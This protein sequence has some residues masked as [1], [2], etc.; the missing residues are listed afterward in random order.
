MNP[1]YQKYLNAVEGELQKRAFDGKPTELY[2]P[3]NYILSLGGKRMRPISVLMGCA[4]FD[5][6]TDKALPA[7]LAIE[8]FHNFTLIHDDIM[9]HAPLRRGKATVHEKWNT[10][11]GILSGDA[12]LVKC[13]DLLLETPLDIQS[14][15]MHLFNK[16]AIEVC[17]GQQWDMNYET[18]REVHGDEY[19]R[20]IEYKT[21]VLLAAALKLG[22]LIGGADETDAQH[23]YEFGRNL[24]LA[25]QIQDDYLD[26]YGAS[27]KVGKQVGGDVLACKKTILLID[28]LESLHGQER[29][30]LIDLYNSEVDNKI[31][32]I[33]A[34]FEK[35]G[36]AAKV[37][38][39]IE[40]YHDTALEHL[41]KIEVEEERK[42]DLRAL[43]EFLINREH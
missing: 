6:E 11:I 21:S 9:D 14:E 19:L 3:M 22:A 7:A 28:A 29:E 30:A 43:A 23:L 2:E 24:G 16:T 17:E 1:T 12:L 20:M 10:S 25:F 5:D 42:A 34:E 32:Q 31:E 37:K 15:L 26:L 39:R 41:H 33:Q 13:Y 40:D 8:W 36:V 35:L 38:R 27:E 18:R 4:L